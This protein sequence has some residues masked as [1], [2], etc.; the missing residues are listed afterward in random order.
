MSIPSNGCIYWCS[1]IWIKKKK[2]KKKKETAIMTNIHLSSFRCR[3]HNWRSAFKMNSV[4]LRRSSTQP[5]SF[6]SRGTGSGH[7]SLLS[8]SRSL[9]SCRMWVV[10]CSD[11][12]HGHI[13]EGTTLSFLWRCLFSLLCPVLSLNR[14]T[15]SVLDSW[16][17]ASFF[18]GGHF[19][20]PYMM[21]HISKVPHGHP[22]YC[23][24][25]L[26]T[27]KVTLHDAICI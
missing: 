4:V 9:H 7:T 19:E 16:W 23:Y 18:W 25:F 15:C 2:K 6:C 3:N 22:T 27:V 11:R 17:Y 5:C 13:G 26:R 12:P 24:I 8:A 21:L 20:S 1:P 14:I 10:S